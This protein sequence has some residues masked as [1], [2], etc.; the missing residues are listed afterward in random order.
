MALKNAPDSVKAAEKAYREANKER[1]RDWR[2]SYDK[3]RKGQNAERQRRWVAKDRERAKRSHY[4][5]YLKKNFGIDIQQYEALLASQGGVCGCCGRSPEQNVKDPKGMP[6]RLGV[7]HDH[8][9]GAI[10]G[11]LC[12]ACNASIGQ[13]GDTLDGLRRAV[14]YLERSQSSKRILTQ[15]E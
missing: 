14:A 5:S 10:R 3:S 8:E 1:I 2:R 7:D 15:P 6:R 13:L 9:T 11:I 4:N 12:H